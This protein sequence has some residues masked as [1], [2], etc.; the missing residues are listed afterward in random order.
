MNKQ[1][2]PTLNPFSVLVNWSESN[3][4]NEGQLYDFMDFEHKALEV[5]KQNPLGGYDKTNVTVT[6]ENGINA[7]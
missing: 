2:T 4:F 6:F 7:D 5:A 1:I 3:E